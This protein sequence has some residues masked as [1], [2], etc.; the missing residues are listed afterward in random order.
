MSEDSAKSVIQLCRHSE[1]STDQLNHDSSLLMCSIGMFLAFVPPMTIIDQVRGAAGPN[2]RGQH[3]VVFLFIIK[4]SFCD[5]K[6]LVLKFVIGHVF[7]WNLESLDC[8]HKPVRQK[9]KDVQTH[10]NPSICAAR[11]F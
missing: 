8:S 10:T 6:D 9:L 3:L 5:P 11:N 1:A 2:Q 4:Y 7:M